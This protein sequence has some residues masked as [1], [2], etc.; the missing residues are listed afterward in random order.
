MVPLPEK[1]AVR[2]PVVPDV[3]WSWSAMPIDDRYFPA[4]SMLCAR[5]VIDLSAEN[6]WLPVMAWTATSRVAAEVVSELVRED[7]DDELTKVA[8][9]STGL[10]EETPSYATS[11][12]DMPVPVCVLKV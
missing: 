2:D 7:V 12:P 6:V 4:G 3:V 11:E 10:T 5:L 8:A 9:A 1:V